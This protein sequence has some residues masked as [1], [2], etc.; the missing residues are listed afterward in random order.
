[1]RKM[2]TLAA[3]VMAFMVTDAVAQEKKPVSPL[4]TVTGSIDGATVE[5]VYSRP[6]AKGRK[7]LGEKEP[8][9]KVWRTG[10]NKATTIEFSKAVKIEGKDL[11]AGKYTL[12]TIPGEKEWV[13]IFNKKLDQWGAYDYEKTKT[14]NALQVTVPAGKPAAFVETFTISIDKDKVTLQWENTSVSFNVKG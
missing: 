2:L 1:M 14:E 12:F 8:Y 7:M 9:G 10:A 3:V 4:E 6:S 5:I 13:I 11:A